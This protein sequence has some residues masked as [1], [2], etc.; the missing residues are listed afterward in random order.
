MIR[1]G[2][3]VWSRRLVLASAPALAAIP[4]AACASSERPAATIGPAEAGVEAGVPPRIVFVSK[5]AFAADFGGVGPA[6]AACQAEAA[7]SNLRNAPRF[8]AW[9]SIADSDGGV[10][11]SPGRIAG[12]GPYAVP[13][14]RV[15]AQDHDALFAAQLALLKS[16]VDEE[17]DGVPAK[18]R[19]VWTGS[20][21]KGTPENDCRGWTSKGPSLGTYGLSGRLDATW[22]F[23]GD[24]VCSDAKAEYRLYCVEG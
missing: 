15:V 17:A 20:T 5:A 10:I 1:R 18:E 14:G 6:D 7:A 13:S 21:A 8:V 9:L 23:A 3:R 11:V 24:V 19:R 4:F 22:I 2:A 12:D 16:G